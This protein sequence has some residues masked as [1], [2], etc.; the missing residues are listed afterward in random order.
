MH[1][2]VGAMKKHPSAGAKG[3]RMGNPLGMHILFTRFPLESRM[4][5]AEVQTLVLMKGLRDRGHDVMFL[6]SCHVLLEETGKLRIENKK[7]KI[8]P[9]PVT[10]W[11]VVNFL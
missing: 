6:G 4:G 8:G 5:G 11:H 1:P 7:L 10:K 3:E 2:S 9:P